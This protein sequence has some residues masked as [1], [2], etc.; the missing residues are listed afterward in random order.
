MPA[1]IERR[2]RQLHEYYMLQVDLAVEQGREQDIDQIV[3]GYP[4]EAAELMAAEPPDEDD[5]DDEPTAAQD[6]SQLLGAPIFI[7]PRSG[8][9]RFRGWRRLSGMFRI[10]GVSK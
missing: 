4:D 10:S 7:E 5:G 8:I 6:G 3:A 2:L 1:D 9:R